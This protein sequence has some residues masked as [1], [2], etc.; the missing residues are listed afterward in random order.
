M[1]PSFSARALS[2]AGFLCLGYFQGAHGAPLPQTE[3]KPPAAPSRPAQA[4]VLLAPA[5]VTTGQLPPK[6]PLPADARKPDRILR[7]GH[8]KPVQALA[9]SADGRWL[10]SGG[11][12]NTIIVWNLSS[13]REEFRLGGQNGPIAPQALNQRAIISLA[14]H[15]DGTRLVSADVSGIIRTWN[16]QTRKLLLA[17]NP[18]RIHYYGG[19]V[20]YSPD[21]KS[22]ILGV[23][24]RT[25]DKTETAIGFYDAETGKSLRTIP[26]NWNFLQVLLPTPDGRMVASGTVGADDD[27]DPSGS[28]QIFDAISGEVQKT[29]PVIA[30]AISPDGKWMASFDNSGPI[31]YHAVL[32][33]VADGRRALELTPRNASHVIFRPDGQE[34][35]ITHGDSNAI[36]FVST[37]TGEVTMSLPGGGYGL[38]TAAYSADGKLLAAGS[39][40]YGTIKVWDLASLKEKVTF[41]GQSPVQNVAFSPDGKLL[42]ATSGELRVWETST[43]NEIRVLTDAP[44][45]RALFSADGKWLAANPGERFPGKTLKIW[46]TQSWKEAGSFTQENGFPAFWF[47]FSDA[48]SAP[49]KIGNVWSWQFVGEGES[50]ILWAS[51]LAMAVSPDG[52][53]LAQPTGGANGAVEIWDAASGQ[54]LHSIPAHKLALMKLAFSRDGRWLLTVGQDSNPM[55]VQGQPGVMIAYPRVSVWD[56]ATW[57]LEFFLTFP[58]SG[59]PGTDIS[60]DGKMLAVTRRGGITQLFDL[61]QKKSIAVFASPEAWP[62]NVAFSPDGTLLVQGAQEG[63]RLWKLSLPAKAASRQPE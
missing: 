59:V 40:S 23:E 27:D 41:Y 30:S 37:A 39:Y 24:K 42:A 21:G 62:G 5:Q 2:A 32:W 15:P 10:A 4:Q 53:W 22:L 45:N 8:S 29:Y 13:G 36:D 50:H 57:Q 28:V 6:E 44:V 52:K 26:T 20:T 9:F 60:A 18:H 3:T 48:K 1:R 17:I 31:G 33:N 19:T 51:S 58:S 49:Q 25:K 56:T 61:E 7:V 38:A 34:M 63:I 14:F 54:K 55:M 11:D 35:A 16:L 46:N 12:D 47:A 43:G